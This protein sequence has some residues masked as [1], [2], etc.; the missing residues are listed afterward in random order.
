MKLS[1]EKSCKIRIILTG[2][3]F[4]LFFLAVVGRGYW[5]QVVD[6]E[7]TVARSRRQYQRIIPLTPRRGAIYD[8]NGA[9]LARSTSVDSVFAEPFRIQNV[10]E[11][12][13]ELAPI[14]RMKFASLRKKLTSNRRFVWLERKVQPDESARIRRLDLEGIAFTKE[15]QRYYPNGGLAAQLLGFTGLD[16]KGLEGLERFYDNQLLGQEGFLVAAKDG[17]R[18]G[19][20]ASN[21]VV[22]GGSH[23]NSLV[24][25]IDRNLQYLA[26]KELALGLK[27]AEGKAG[28]VVMLDPVSGEILAMANR[29]TYNPNAFSRFPAASRRNRAV[30]D[31]FEPGSTLKVFLM[32]AALNENLVRPNQ[33]VDCEHGAYRVGGMTIHDHHPY[34]DLRIVDVLAKSSNI[35]AAKVGKLLERQRYFEYLQ[36]FGFGEQTGIDFP[37]EASGQLRRPEQWFEGDL[38]AISFGQGMTVTALQMARAVAAIANGGVLMKADLVRQVLDE[39]GSV[40]ERRTPQTVRR[41]V[42]EKTAAQVRSMMEMVTRDGGT[43]TRAAVP[44]YR[45]AGKTGTAQKVDPVTGG[46]SADKR[47]ASFVG[48]APVDHPRL[49]I[50]V[51]IDEPKTHVYGGWVAAPVFSRLAGQALRYLGVSPTETDMPGPLPPVTLETEVAITTGQTQSLATT[52]EGTPVMPSCLGLSCRQ[53]LRVMEHQGINIRIKGSGKVVE[54]FPAPGQTIRYGDEVWVKL[55]PPA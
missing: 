32:A 50:M 46:Y 23:G 17:R 5:L 44:G 14:L 2:V 16:P 24:L 20:G 18:K 48:F 40:V 52:A 49:V 4:T 9:E 8:R 31:E 35:G 3:G 41:V 54:Q 39:E 28:S 43:G 38:A 27:E 13:R 22:Q 10:D 33:V 36:H 34:D 12:V 30:C 26:E 1:P 11:A 21:M 55:Q 42:S 15:H 29:P 6:S 47:V 37:G 45:V 7:A 53:V 25:T 19:L 51:M